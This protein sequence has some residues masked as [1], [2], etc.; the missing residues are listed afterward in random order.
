MIL[1]RKKPV[2]HKLQHQALVEP[3]QQAFDYFQEEKRNK[4]SS[5][6]QNL[7]PQ[8][9]LECIRGSHQINGEVEGIFLWVY[10]MMKKNSGVLNQPSFMESSEKQ[11]EFYATLT[12]DQSTGNMAGPMFE[13]SRIDTQSF[14]S[15]FL[16]IAQTFELSERACN[17]LINLTRRYRN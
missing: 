9:G 12:N 14:C 8:N 1:R 3:Q 10:W 17:D 16:S 11:T 13:G 2:V 5:A 7:I 6:Q 4:E 15:E